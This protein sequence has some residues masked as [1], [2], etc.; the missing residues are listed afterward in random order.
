MATATARLASGCP[1]MYSE[2]CSTMASVVSG[3]L[4]EHEEAQRR[5]M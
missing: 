5:N 2:S 3:E 1:T 4:F